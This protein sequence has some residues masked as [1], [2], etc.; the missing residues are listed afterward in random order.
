VS[1]TALVV[2]NVTDADP[3]YVGDGFVAR[4]FALRPVMREHGEVPSEVPDGTDVVLLLGSAWSVV[5]PV[6]PDVLEAEVALVR[7]AQA[8]GVPVL[9]LCYGA[10]VSAHA[11]GGEVSRAPEPEVGLVHVESADPDLVPRGPWWEFHTDVVSPPEHATVVARN[12]CGVQAYV[13][14]GL[15]GVQ[16]HPE[17]RPDTLADW[18]HRYPEMA[19][20]SGHTPEWLV[21]LARHREDDARRAAYALVDAF[22]AATAA[23]PKRL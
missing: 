2:G 12:A 3:G 4:G 19:A 20:T 23:A 7:A 1:P 15:V 13:L 14:P 18:I 10:Q 8:G 17:V 9:G 22:L 16:F 21:K 11:L 6:R 5:E